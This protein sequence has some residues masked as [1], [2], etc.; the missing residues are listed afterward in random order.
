MPAGKSFLRKEHPQCTMIR[1]RTDIKITLET[2]HLFYILASRT[3]FQSFILIFIFMDY[4]CHYC[5]FCPYVIWKENHPLNTNVFLRLLANWQTVRCENIRCENV[6]C[7]TVLSLKSPSYSK[8]AI[9]CDWRMFR[10]LKT[11]K[12]RNVLKKQIVFFSEKTWIFNLKNV[13]RS[14]FAVESA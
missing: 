14:V 3:F 13:E 10:F 4:F 12:T 11:N 6:R 8:F 5:Y 7:S 1:G 2:L 9:E